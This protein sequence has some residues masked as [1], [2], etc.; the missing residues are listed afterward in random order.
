ME[1]I[2]YEFKETSKKLNDYIEKNIETESTGNF[3][4][5][6]ELME[7]YSRLLGNFAMFEL[8]K[9]LTKKRNREYSRSHTPTELVETTYLMTSSDYEDRFRA[10]YW[11][12]VIRYEKLKAM[13][14]KWD[15]G[16]LNFTPTCPRETYD[17]QI[18][19]MHEYISILEQR[20]LLEGVNLA[21]EE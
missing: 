21:R 17:D 18:A 15:K 20:A 8:S 12:N 6:I 9:E 7:V 13:L 3:E 16:L 10:E 4:K 14:E 5:T 1:Q 19:S 11:Q 2:V